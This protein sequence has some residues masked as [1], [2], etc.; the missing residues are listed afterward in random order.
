MRRIN[1]EG[2][3]G[4]AVISKSQLEKAFSIHNGTQLIIYYN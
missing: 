1:G 4:L 2:F 3:G